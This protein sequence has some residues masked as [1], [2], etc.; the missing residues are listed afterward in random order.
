MSKPTSRFDLWINSLVVHLAQNFKLNRKIQSP[1][2][3]P[4]ATVEGW[5][6]RSGFRF[7]AMPPK[8]G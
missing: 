1:V 3:Y 8:T 7:V 6:K 5:Q 2:G 4:L